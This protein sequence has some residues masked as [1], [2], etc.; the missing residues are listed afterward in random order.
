M[1]RSNRYQ[2]LEHQLFQPLS[3]VSLIFR[4]FQTNNFQ[5]ILIHKS[6]Q[7]G[8]YIFKISD[9]NLS[10]SLTKEGLASSTVGTLLY[11]AP[12]LFTRTEYNYKVDL[13]SIG[14]MMFECITGKVPFYLAK[15]FIN[16]QNYRN[17]LSYVS[18]CLQN[19]IQSGLK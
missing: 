9:F 14:I 10:R 4:T 8:R 12:E 16:D 6:L 7:T 17:E 3:F 11:A 2:R 5:N 13:W 19:F 15:K 1:A 18:I